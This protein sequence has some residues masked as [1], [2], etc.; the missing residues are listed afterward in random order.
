MT[1]LSAD[2]EQENGLIIVTCEMKQVV[3]L[4]GMG[5]LGL[6]LCLFSLVKTRLPLSFILLSTCWMAHNI[7]P[8]LLKSGIR[9]RQS[10][11]RSGVEVRPTIH[12]HQSIHSPI[13]YWS[14]MEYNVASCWFSYTNYCPG[15]CWFADNKLKATFYW[16]VLH[17]ILYGYILNRNSLSL[18]IHIIT[19]RDLAVCLVY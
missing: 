2:G 9:S 1:I 6:L 18:A 14:T 5:R 7:H 19:N 15:I 16:L 4:P 17:I 12:C 11:N 8:L 13:A 10:Q 3:M